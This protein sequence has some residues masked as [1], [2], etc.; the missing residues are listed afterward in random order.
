M[1]WRTLQPTTINQ[2]AGVSHVLGSV[3]EVSHEL[4]ICVKWRRV[5]QDQVQ[6]SIEVKVQL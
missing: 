1:K 3:K 5:L 6:L 2:V 4:E